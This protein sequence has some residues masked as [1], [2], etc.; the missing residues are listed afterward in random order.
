M[1]K[2]TRPRPSRRKHETHVAP[3]SIPAATWRYLPL[4][5]LVALS[6]FIA[7]LRIHTYE[8]PFERDITSHAVIAHEMLAGHPLYSDLWDSKPP[9]IFVTYAIA[10]ALVGYGPSQVYFIGVVAAIITLVGAYWAGS[11]YGGRVGGLIA[12]AFWAV[13]CNDLYL[14]ANQPNIEAGMNACLVWAFALMVRADSNKLQLPR[15]LGIGALFA[16]ATL[17]KP[18]AITFPA[19]L[20]PFYLLVNLRDSQARKLALL[21]VCILLAVGAAA[22]GLTFA[23]FAVTGR[24]RIFYD[25][26]FTYA[27]YYAQSRGGNFF[28]NILKGLTHKSF[29]LA[30]KSTPVL[31]VFTAA[32]IIFGLLKGSRRHWLLLLAFV[33]AAY[34][35]VALPGR[36]YNHYYQLW[37]CPLVVGAGWAVAT[38]GGKDKPKLTPLRYIA[39]VVGFVILLG[40]VLPQYKF[41]PDEWSARK[42]GPQYITVKEIATELDQLLKPDETLYVL[43]INPG[44]YFWPKRRPP[45]GVIW[46]PDMA[47]NPLAEAHTK[48]AL[49]DLEREKPEIFVVN[50]L[51]AQVPPDHPVV[52]WAQA[53]YM[54]LPGNPNRGTWYGRPFF[55]ILIRRGGK[56]AARLG[57]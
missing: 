24:F 48:R 22:W 54:P 21:H 38:I 37:L 32:G 57:A 51:H 40:F 25:T 43:G 5:V 2:R 53:N 56:L 20:G 15:W 7:I 3:R 18:V 42:Q 41:P 1:K 35:A 49:A 12:A 6:A 26:I 4:L 52:K 10:D 11:A 39:G 46:S 55:R 8:E 50:L 33:L 9:A 36:F 34:L 23:Y 13:I 44:F 29:S 31:L 28:A 19:V 16:L 14:W 45:T 27:R 30:M 17:Y 47:D